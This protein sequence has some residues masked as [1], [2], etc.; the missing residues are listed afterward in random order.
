MIYN[1]LCFVCL[2]LFLL[3]SYL[4]FC[5]MFRILKKR[6]SLLEKL[7]C[8][9]RAECSGS[10]HQ[11]LVEEKPLEA[12][13]RPSVPHPDPALTSE[14]EIADARQASGQD[15]EVD[16]SV[17]TQAT[18]TWNPSDTQGKVFVFKL[19]PELTDLAGTAPRKGR[20]KKRNYLN[21]KKG[22]IAPQE[23]EWRSWPGRISSEAAEHPWPDHPV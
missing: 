2:C 11:I 1:W 18:Q 17:S 3:Y 15:M 7:F 23:D 16:V 20:R 4:H 10:T 9:P 6:Q 5:W 8:P 13:G 22:A 21:F 14:R 19:Q 12:S